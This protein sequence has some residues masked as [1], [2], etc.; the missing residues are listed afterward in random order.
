MYD[1]RLDSVIIQPPVGRNIILYIY[2]YILTYTSL[3]YLLV[4]RKLP[5]LGTLY[6][7]FCLFLCDFC[8]QVFL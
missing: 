4:R 6:Q 7:L 2:Y 5:F 8:C 1:P 3:C